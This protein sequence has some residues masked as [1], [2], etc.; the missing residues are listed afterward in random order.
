MAATKTDP[1]DIQFNSTE[2]CMYDI[3]FDY[4]HIKTANALS[5]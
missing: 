3:F 4:L 2:K 5:K 1:K